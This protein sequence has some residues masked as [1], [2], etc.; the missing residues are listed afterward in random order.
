MTHPDTED[1]CSICDSIDFMMRN[2]DALRN[3]FAQLS[4]LH[5]SISQKQ[6][7]SWYWQN[8]LMHN[9]SKRSMYT[10]KCNYFMRME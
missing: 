8:M 10:I 9:V 3:E 6:N 7:I 2:C 4:L 1:E 5:K